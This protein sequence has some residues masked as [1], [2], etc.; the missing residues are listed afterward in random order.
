MATLTIFLDLLMWAAAGHLP[1]FC[2]FDSVAENALGPMSIPHPASN[3]SHNFSS[4]KKPQDDQPNQ[5]KTPEAN[6]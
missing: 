4:V 3:I 6:V 1:H 2:G 5:T